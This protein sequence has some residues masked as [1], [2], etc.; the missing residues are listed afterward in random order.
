M[1]AA[2]HEAT[3]RERAY[4]IWEEEGRPNGC[5]LQHWERAYREILTSIG[6]IDERADAPQL[7]KKRKTVK[8]RIRSAFKSAMP[9]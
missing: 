8:S 1:E 9:A 7:P 2:L 5:E 6:V 4:A 3:I